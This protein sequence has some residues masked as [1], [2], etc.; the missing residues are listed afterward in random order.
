[1]D[2]GPVTPDA[3]LIIRPR[4]R[5]LNPSD[6]CLHAAPASLRAAGDT[7]PWPIRVHRAPPPACRDGDIAAAVPPKERETCGSGPA[8]RA[9]LPNPAPEGCRG[10]SGGPYPEF[11]AGECLEYGLGPPLPDST[12]RSRPCPAPPTA[13]GLWGPERPPPEATRPFPPGPRLAGL[14][15]KTAAAD[16]LPRHGPARMQLPASPPN[17]KR[18]STE[19]SGSEEPCP[20]ADSPGPMTAP[21]SA[22]PGPASDTTTRPGPLGARSGLPGTPR[23]GLRTRRVSRRHAVTDTLMFRRVAT[24][25]NRQT[26]RR[27][28]FL[29]K[30]RDTDHKR[31]TGFPQIR[32]GTVRLP[33]F[34]AGPIP[35]NP[36]CC[37]RSRD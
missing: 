34:T 33:A 25:D 17:P 3:F 7:H 9:C 5:P 6:P 4:G 37:A 2:A 23:S 26:G 22:V 13:S 12:R 15:P 36:R 27:R 21:C 10:T 19:G 1:M 8:T 29:C 32:R 20:S 11:L 31:S 30:T 35:G 16:P 14:R 18:T 24:G 28:S